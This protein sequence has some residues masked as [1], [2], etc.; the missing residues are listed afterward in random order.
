MLPPFIR[1]KIDSRSGFAK[2]LNNMGWLTIDKFIR[3]FLSLLVGVWVARYLG[4]TSFGEL[5]YIVAFVGIF[6]TIAQLGLDNIAIRDMSRCPELAK[7]ILGTIFR[8]RMALGI[9]CYIVAIFSIRII[10]ADDDQAL[11]LVAIVAGVLIFQSADTADLW[12]QSLLQSKRTVLAKSFAYIIS[13]LFKIALI[14]MQ[15]PLTAFAVVVLLEASL[16]ALALLYSYKKYPPTG[17]FHWNFRRCQTLLSEGFP[18]LLSGVILTAYLQLDRILLELMTS[19]SEVGYYMAA[20]NLSSAI[21]F[22]PIILCTSLAPKMAAIQIDAE[23]IL[24]FVK[25]NTILMW[26][27]FFTT[28][29]FFLSADKIIL[30]L[31]GERYESSAL[32]LK[33]QAFSIAPIFLSVANDYL[34]LNRGKGRITLL[35]TVTGL[36][37]NLALNIILIPQ[38]GAVG[39]AVSALATHWISNTVLYWFIM[40][41]SFKI[42]TKAVGLPF[43]VLYSKLKICKVNQR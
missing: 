31:Y 28:L 35:R 14:L 42:Q 10:Q 1:R 39:A 5:A 13:N 37:V 4:P 3:I 29:A 34:A 41:D 36:L 18:F 22:L 21:N 6:Q 15:L 25:L 27:A 8:L 17:K 32:V 43:L 20:M 19:S 12:F 9:I 23:K 7:E 11:L 26:A 38:S 24:F 30:L 40:R 16:S 2:I 33:I